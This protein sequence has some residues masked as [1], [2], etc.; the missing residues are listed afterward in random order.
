[1]TKEQLK[2]LEYTSIVEENSTTLHIHLQ[3]GY[4]LYNY[5]VGEYEKDDE[6][7]KFANLFGS[8]C[9]YFPVKEE[10]P[11]YT[12]CTTDEYKQLEET[13]ASANDEERVRIAETFLGNE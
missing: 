2:S 7:V 3:P 8:D 9:F 13:F 6:T 11:K 1:M 5:E 10:Y 4:V 12:L